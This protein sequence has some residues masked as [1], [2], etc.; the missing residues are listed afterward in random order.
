[1]GK[2]PPVPVRYEASLP[3]NQTRHGREKRKSLTLPVIKF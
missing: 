2:E 1:M 3:Q